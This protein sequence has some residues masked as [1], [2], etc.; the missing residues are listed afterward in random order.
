MPGAE[1]GAATSRVCTR[2]NLIRAPPSRRT[3]FTTP[4]HECPR[5]GACRASCRYVRRARRRPRSLQ[6]DEAIFVTRSGPAQA[7]ADF[8]GAHRRSSV[9][10]HTNTMTFLR[11]KPLGHV[12]DSGGL[13]KSSLLEREPATLQS[14]VRAPLPLAESRLSPRDALAAQRTDA[15]CRTIQS[16]RVRGKHASEQRIPHSK[17][18][19]SGG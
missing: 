7:D 9:C 10:Y 3:V 11:P 4:D 12:P 17:P 8:R 19:R 6:P 5:L 13:S 1:L 2:D 14:L 18:V 16:I 15:M